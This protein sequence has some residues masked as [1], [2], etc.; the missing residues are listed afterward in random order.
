RDSEE[1]KKAYSSINSSDKLALKISQLEKLCTESEL[2]NVRFLNPCGCEKCNKEGGVSGESGR[3]VVMEMIVL[4]DAD[5]QFIIKEDD[6]GW[7]QHLK[8]QGWPDIK[9]HCKSRIVRGQV[10]ILSASEQVDDLVPVPV[11][12]IYRAM[13]EAL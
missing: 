9:D 4:D 3:L 2:K 6:L 10:D 11:T 5:R 1:A 8:K 12:D 13:Q 7:K